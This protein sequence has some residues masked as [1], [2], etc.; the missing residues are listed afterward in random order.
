VRLSRGRVALRVVLLAVGGAWM[1]WRGAIARS[2]AR[3]V[4]GGDALLGSRL[5]LVWILMGALALAT[6]LSAAASLR[7][8]PPKRTLHLDDLSGSRRRR[9]EGQ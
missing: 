2:A 7:R 9:D 3:P 4:E 1:L 8:R 5:A 6:A